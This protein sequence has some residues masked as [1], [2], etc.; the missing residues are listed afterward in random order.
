MRESVGRMAGLIN[1]VLDFA[2]GR[3]GGGIPVEHAPDARLGDA[4]AQVV[5]ELRS[6]RPDRVIESDI[7]LDKVVTCDSARIAQLFSNL[8][9]NALTHG[10]AKAPVRVRAR[11]EGG[12]FELWVANRGAPIPP[13]AAERLF[14]P[15][16]RASDRSADKGLG[17]GLWIA[18]EIARAHSGTLQLSSTLDET[19]FTFRMPLQAPHR[20]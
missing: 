15:F 14:Q 18:S 20:L 3:L 12:R 9:G 7:V 8:L 4:L 11:T 19:R 16:T 13:D 5:G 1:N 6:T 17:L 10:D 2:R